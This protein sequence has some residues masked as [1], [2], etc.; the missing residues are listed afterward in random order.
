[1]D[2][3]LVPVDPAKLS[4]GLKTTFLGVSLIFD[5]LGASEAALRSFVNDAQTTDAV[6]EA[7]DLMWQAEKRMDDADGV[8][9]ADAADKPVETPPVDITVKPEKAALD[10]TPATTARPTV[11]DKPATTVQPTPE[12]Q[13]ATMTAQ[14]A[15][16][17][18]VDDITKVIVAKIKKKRSNNEAIGKLLKAYGAVKVSELD[19][20]KYEAFLTDI[21]QM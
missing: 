1:M 6:A 5:S 7:L 15:P 4:Q 20:A 16:S 12:K 3:N 10:T 19:P 14:P 21:S 9:N 17:V 2:K 18:T 8:A 11:Q 13:P